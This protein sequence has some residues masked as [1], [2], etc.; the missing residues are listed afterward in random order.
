MGPSP[1]LRHGLVALVGCLYV[2]LS[3]W[4]VGK[5]GQS[6]REGLRRE[7]IAAHESEK[8][9]PPPELKNADSTAIR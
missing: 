9:A 2:A 3:I 1:M 5:Q 4:I 6:Y 7:R 8:P